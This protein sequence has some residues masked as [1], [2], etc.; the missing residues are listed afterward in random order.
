MR[1]K[2]DVINEKS[3]KEEK[4]HKGRRK[5]AC[6]T[7]SPKNKNKR[8][9]VQ[10]DSFSLGNDHVGYAKVVNMSMRKCLRSNLPPFLPSP[11]SYINA[12]PHLKLHHLFP[13][14]LNRATQ[15]NTIQSASLSL[16]YR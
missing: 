2:D 13:L 6:V 7:C 9:K 14:P 8:L 3:R 12:T 10:F 4:A 11:S 16:F 5:K 1:T 15:K